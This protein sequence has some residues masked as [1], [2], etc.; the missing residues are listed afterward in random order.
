[1]VFQW[2]L[3]ESKSRQVSWTL[4]SILAVLNKAVVWTVSILPVISNSSSPCTNPFVTVPRF[5]IT[6]GIIFTFIFHRFFQFHCKIEVFILFFHC[7]QFYSVISRDSKVHIIANS[8][9][10]FFLVIIIRSCR[11]AE[12][13]RSVFM[14]KT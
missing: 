10:F 9:F 8:F 14:S 13:R 2:S 7:L 5:P 12:I 11:L 6:I 4:L 1:M 3:S